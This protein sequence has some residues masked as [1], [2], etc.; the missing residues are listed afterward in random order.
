M[1]DPLSSLDRLTQLVQKI[2]Q[3]R[4]ITRAEQA[5]LMDIVMEDGRVSP[6]E[7]VMIDRVWRGL[8]EGRVR[9]LD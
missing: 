6:E 9:V 2:L 8:A 7:Q 4:T 1:A 3:T 5:Q